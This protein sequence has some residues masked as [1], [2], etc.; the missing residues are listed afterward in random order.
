MV[1]VVGPEALE[2][3]RHGGQ[4]KFGQAA[5]TPGQAERHDLD[6]QDAVRPSVGTSSS[7]P[8]RIISRRAAAATIFL[9]TRRFPVP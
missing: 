6:R 5:P 4:A 2:S 9:R 1:A 8:T 7:A 3:A